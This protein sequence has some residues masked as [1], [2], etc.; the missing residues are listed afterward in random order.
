MNI[1]ADNLTY[2]R[3]QKKLTQEQAAQQLGEKVKTYQAWEEGRAMPSLKK[4]PKICRFYDFY[5]IYK[6]M[7][8]RI[9]ISNEPFIQKR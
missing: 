7:H 3:K 6:L 5:D 1:F 8:N 4:V 9:T 2:L